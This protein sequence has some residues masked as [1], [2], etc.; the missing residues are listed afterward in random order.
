MALFKIFKGNS[1]S[2]PKGKKSALTGNN[3]PYTE[4]FAYFT[5]DTGRF[6][7]DANDER[8]ALNAGTVKFAQADESNTDGSN[9]TIS[10]G[11]D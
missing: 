11:D 4:G 8:I 1:E 2:L 10:I 5:P 3:L 9:L 7:I 6:Y